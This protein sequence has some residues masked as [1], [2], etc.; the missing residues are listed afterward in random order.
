[1]IIPNL[2]Q[3]TNTMSNIVP[4]AQAKSTPKTI[5]VVGIVSG[6]TASMK[7]RF[8][9]SLWHLTSTLA[10]LR[11]D[12]YNTP[13]RGYEASRDLAVGRLTT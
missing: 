9:Q 13:N 5:T 3:I 4:T 8:F 6:S 7:V 1:M 11:Y 12:H 10:A 2:K